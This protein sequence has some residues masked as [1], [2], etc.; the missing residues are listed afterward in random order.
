MQWL[1]I[2][3]SMRFWK[4]SFQTF[5]IYSFNSFYAST[6]SLYT[7]VSYV[8][9]QFRKNVSWSTS[10]VCD[11][12]ISVEKLWKLNEYTKSIIR[13]LSWSKVKRSRFSKRWL[14]KTWLIWTSRN[15][16]NKIINKWWV[17]ETKFFSFQRDFNVNIIV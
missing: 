16:L 14:I 13:L 17:D 8:S 9:I 12:F 7:T 6:W 4:K 2:S 11:N 5:S 10:W 1:T 3:I 15:E